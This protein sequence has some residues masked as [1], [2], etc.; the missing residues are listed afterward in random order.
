MN[1]CVDNN[2]GVWLR[3][4]YLKGKGVSENTIKKWCNRKIVI[5]KKDSNH[6][7]ILYDTIPTPTRK[8][9]PDKAMLLYDFEQEQAGGLQ[10]HFFRELSE[11]YN[12]P[13]SGHWRNEI[14]KA[15]GTFEQ[16]KFGEKVNEFAKKA[17]VF[18]RI[19][20]IYGGKRG[21]LE[22]LHKAYLQLFPGNFSMKNRFCMA[23]KQAKEKGI[24]PVAVNG[25]CLNRGKVIYGEEHR[26]IAFEYL[27][28]PKGYDSTVAYDL[29]VS[30]CEH[31]G[32]D[33]PCFKWF[34]TY[35]KNNLNRINRGRLGETQFQ[36]KNGIR[37]K[38]IPALYIGDQW[39]IDGWKIPLWGKKLNE[40][41]KME[42]F[43]SHILFTVV[44]AHSRKIIGYHIAE[45]ENTEMILTHIATHP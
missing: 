20:S 32:I 43:V 15:H 12:A 37:R 31:N 19:L 27:S 30:D 3:R 33:T 21:E 29:F 9:L 35:R 23:I 16:I 44:D 6:T 7:C 17:A 40:K 1:V 36:A 18:E 24:L 13:G 22:A 11:A 14:L 2:K 28:D 26:S 25:S 42:D 34:W 45:S 4:N 8:K 39:Q 38:I 41:G 10:Q 5:C